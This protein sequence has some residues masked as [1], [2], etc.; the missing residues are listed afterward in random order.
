MPK[1][2]T[3]GICE[4]QNLPK[5]SNPETNRAEAVRRDKKENDGDERR[6][7][8]ISKR[9]RVMVRMEAQ[10]RERERVCVSESERLRFFYFIFF[11]IYMGRVWIISIPYPNYLSN[12]H[13][14]PV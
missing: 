14:L 4:R 6:R 1:P 13:T 2:I 11:I 8:E 9:E 12:I 10:V 7:L 3:V 5:T